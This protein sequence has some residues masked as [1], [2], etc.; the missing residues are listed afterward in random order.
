VLDGLKRPEGIALRGE[1][2]YVVDVAGREVIESDLAGGAR[3]TIASNLAV[4]APPG[5]E[6]KNLGA[7]G[8]MSGRWC[9]S[10]ASPRGQT[11][12]SISRLTPKAACWRCARP[13]VRLVSPAYHRPAKHV[14]MQHTMQVVDIA[15][16]DRVW[17]CPFPAA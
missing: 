14:L 6:R 2:L 8:V 17:P 12:R 7:V 5:V 16:L 10:P 3:R 13:E 4:G 9:P 11:A 15:L 1:R